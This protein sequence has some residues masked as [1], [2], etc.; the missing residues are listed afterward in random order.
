MLDKQMHASLGHVMERQH[1][2]RASPHVASITFL[3]PKGHS[4]VADCLL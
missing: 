2:A 3:W 4:A 1:E